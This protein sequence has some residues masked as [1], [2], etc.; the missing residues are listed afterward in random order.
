M[1]GKPEGDIP[2]KRFRCGWENNIKMEWCDLI[3]DTP[4]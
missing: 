1:M 3:P 4:L 2:L